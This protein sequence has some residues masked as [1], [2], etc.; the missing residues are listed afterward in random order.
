MF[1]LDINQGC[2]GFVIGLQLAAI[3]SHGTLSRLAVLASDPIVSIAPDIGS[4]VW[5]PALA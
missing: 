2:A 3:V 5:W 4:I 1:C